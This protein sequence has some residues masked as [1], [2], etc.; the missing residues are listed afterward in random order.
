MFMD[1]LDDDSLLDLRRRARRTDPAAVTAEERSERT[2]TPDT[3]RDLAD[4]LR[5][6]GIDRVGTEEGPPPDGE[7]HVCKTRS[8]KYTCAQCGRGA[9]AAHQWVMFGL[10]HRCATEDRIRRWHAQGRPEA[11]NWL[12]DA[13]EDPGDD[14]R[15]P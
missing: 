7:C 6:S 15:R 3:N 2:E 5:A 14:G 10:C 1:L 13:A 12:D 4:W 11:K 9:C 8:A